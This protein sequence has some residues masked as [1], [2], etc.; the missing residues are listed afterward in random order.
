VGVVVAVE[1]A[2]EELRGLE[3][4]VAEVKAQATHLVVVLR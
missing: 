3:A 1:W 2:K 4:Q